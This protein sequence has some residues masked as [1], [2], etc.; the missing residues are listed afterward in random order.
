MTSSAP[1]R[2]ALG[3]VS[4]N[5]LV[6]PATNSKHVNN[7]HTST[8]AKRA[9]AEEGMALPKTSLENN[10][11]AQSVANISSIG[12]KRSLEVAQNM[13]EGRK[14]LK[15]SLGQEGKLQA[16]AEMTQSYAD[17][18][19]HAKSTAIACKSMDGGEDRLSAASTSPASSFHSS[20]AALDDSQQ[21][22][23]TEPDLSP[24][25]APNVR[26]PAYISNR[27]TSS[28]TKSEREQKY[29]QMK[30]RLQLAN[31]KVQTDQIDVPIANL[32]LR[33]I[34]SSPRP[35]PADA[36][37]RPS[38]S[39][40]PTSWPPVPTSYVPKIQLQQPSTE[41]K[42]SSMPCIPSAPP[43]SFRTEALASPRT[44]D[45]P[46]DDF[47]TPILPQQREGLLNPPLGSPED[48][49]LTGSAVN[50]S[51]ASDLL[52]LRDQLEKTANRG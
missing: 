37:S 17:R 24:L 51:A 41:K 52:L 10:Q 13:D 50:G 44:E 40:G 4:V 5:M 46:R 43:P 16:Y 22:I 12:E 18:E 38:T 11:S 30:L 7:T 23:L 47:A 35:P 15:R 2:R 14:K 9:R 34:P 45:S 19:N 21:T 1:T 29:A 20:I 49:K 27:S 26:A 32:E 36:G 48:A 31:Y 3:D 42:K 8:S 6:A 39:A 33:S 25:P 28:L